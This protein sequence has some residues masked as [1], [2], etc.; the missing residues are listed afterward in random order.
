[1][2]E[3]QSESA[4]STRDT[5]TQAKW[6]K[7]APNFDVMAGKG[8]EDRWEPFKTE[9]FANMTDSGR[10]L[11][12]ALG[13]ALDIKFF[14]PGR[15]ITAIDIS[16]VMLDVAAPRVQGYD[17]QIDAQVMDVHNMDFAP[18]SFDQVFTSCTFCSVPNPVE[19]LRKTCRR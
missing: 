12:L 10:I 18:G 15:Q 9:L 2:S 7:L 11:F 14:P 13:T 6:D 17:G 3:I 1:M 8:A 16:P 5:V 19:A 4:A